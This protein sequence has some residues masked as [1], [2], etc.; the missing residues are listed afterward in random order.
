M[1]RHLLILKYKK[2]SFFFLLHL[3]Y[4]VRAREWIRD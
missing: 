2:S 3:C 1:E 4:S